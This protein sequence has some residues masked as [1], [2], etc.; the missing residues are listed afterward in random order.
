MKRL[1]RSNIVHFS[2]H[3]LVLAILAIGYG[4]LSPAE[5][6]VPSELWSFDKVI[7][8]VSFGVLT[9]LIWL[10]LYKIGNTGWTLDLKA[11]FWGIF[12]GLLVEVLQYY[13]PIQRSGDGMDFL[14]DVL[15]SIAAVGFFRLIRFNR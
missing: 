12:A 14:A 8:F 2:S 7:H 3:L 4:T 11:L 9:A 15:G 10:H 13:L 5:Y 6:L 1:I